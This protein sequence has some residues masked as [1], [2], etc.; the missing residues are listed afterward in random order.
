MKKN[1]LFIALLVGVITA[2][3]ENFTDY[4][5]PF[6]GTAT[7]GH[8]YPGAVLP[9]GLV[10]VGPDTN[11]QGWPVSSGYHSDQPTIMGF[12]HTHMT[13][14]GAPEMG[15]ILIVPITGDAKFDAGNEKDT[16]TGYRSKYSHAT[17]VAHPGY[18]AVTLDDYNIRA[19]ITATLRAAIHRYTYPASGVCGVIIDTDHGI[20]DVTLESYVKVH[21]NNTIVGMRRSKGFIKDNRYYFCARFEQPFASTRLND[22]GDKIYL[23]FNGVNGKQLL[24]KIGLSTVSEEGAMKNLD[25]EIPAWDFAAVESNATQVWN[26]YLSRFEIEPFN[27]DQRTIFYTAL[28]HCLICPNLITDVDGYYRGWDQKVHQSKEGDYYTNFSLWDTYRA[29]HPL[30]NLVYPEVN[31][32]FLRSMMQRYRE[33]G[34][35]PIN[36]Y[37][38][39]ETECMIGYHAVP[40]LAEAVLMNRPG[41]DYNEALEAMKK[42]AMDDR[43]GVGD[44]KKLGFVPS[45]KDNYSVSETME[46]SY[47]DWC[48]AMVAKKLGK[49]DD[50]NYFIKRSHNYLNHFDP[51][52][53]FMRGRHADGSWVTPFDPKLVSPWG[54]GDF[55]EGNSWHYTFY[56]PHDMTDFITKFGGKKKFCQRLD[57]M[58]DPKNRLTDAKD[59]DITGVYG[60]YVQGNEPCHHVAYLYDFGGEPW[61]AQKMI[62]EIK[63]T[64]YLNSRDGLCGNDDCGQMSAWYLYGCLGFYPVTPGIGYYVIGS[65]SLKKAVI[66]L[67][68]GKDFTVTAPKAQPDVF[69]INSARL[70]GKKFN[71]TYIN[72]SE[73]QAGGT[74]NFN[75]STKPNN[76]WGTKDIPVAISK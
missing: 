73:I 28:Y 56:E 40:V 70:N 65:P 38:T 33:I 16:S 62:A 68:G 52:T 48:I 9:F 32:S 51:E 10:Q 18:Y 4:V 7:T 22:K 19:E 37:G 39:C 20:E 60:Q 12:S 23:S 14:T 47:D 15:D 5:D 74:L 41:L 49:T 31:E 3:A 43:R 61:K 53:G 55:T 42:A 13:G 36:E 75:L 72:I 54:I 27:K 44:M 29:L 21:D 11:T 67:P 17:E 76:S 24:V 57:E 46:Y 35:L 58:F 34:Q 45:E 1:L 63:N 25:A 6:I 30:L 71:R 8:T 59:I 26:K 2:N 64:F 50:Y 66:H 69:Y